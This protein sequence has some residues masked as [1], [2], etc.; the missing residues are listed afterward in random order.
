MPT[1]GEALT[2]HESSGMSV[3]IFDIFPFICTAELDRTETPTL[4]AVT[5]IFILR[6]G[7]LST[8]S[9]FADVPTLTDACS[10][11]SISCTLPPL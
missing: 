1:K 9:F 10:S 7:V 5:V 8:T 3:P 11:N 2:T 6:P 4:F